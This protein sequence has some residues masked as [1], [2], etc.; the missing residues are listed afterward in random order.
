M[1]VFV[2]R[3]GSSGRYGY[4]LDESGANLPKV[5]SGPWRKYSTLN[6]DGATRNVGIEAEDVWSAIRR[7]GYS[8]TE[9]LVKVT[10]LK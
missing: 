1:T 6:L 9:K 7:Y 2:F 8:M 5:P 3:S 10:P 4:T